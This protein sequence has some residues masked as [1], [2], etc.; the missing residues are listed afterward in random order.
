MGYQITIGNKT[1]D[2]K[3][4]FTIKE[5]FNETLDSGTV[6]F[7]TYG[8]ELKCEPFDKATIFHTDNIITPKILEVDSITDDIYC[9]GD[10]LDD[11]DHLYTMTLFSETKDLERATM[12][13]CAISQPLD[14][15]TDA[16]ITVRDAIENYCYC[17]LPK[18]KIASNNAS[19]FSYTDS[20]KI[21][22]TVKDKFNGVL[23]PEF[24][25]DNP[26]LREVLNDLF[27]VKDCIPVVK[28]NVI[29]L[30]DLTAKNN[31][32]DT[33]RL[34][35]MTS[36]FSSNDYVS[37]LTM[38]MK[39][40]VGKRIT[41]SAPYQCC[42]SVDESGEIN[43]NNMCI[44][45]QKPI[46]SVKSLKI[47]FI[48]RNGYHHCCDVAS[49]TIEYDDW[50]LKSN[51]NI[52]PSSGYY[53]LP[54][55][56]DANG[57]SAP[58]HRVNYIYYKRG[59]NTVENLSTKYNEGLLNEDYLT[60]LCAAY[61]SSC[62]VLRSMAEGLAGNF[63]A[64]IKTEPRTMFYEIEYETL[65][66]NAMHF[67]KNIPNNHPENRMF[68]NQPNAYVDIQ[69]QSIFEYAKVNRLS[70]QIKEVYSEYDNESEVPALGD[71]IDEYILFSKETTYYDNKMLFHGFLTKN[72]ILK[73]YYTGIMAKKRSWQIASQDD[74]LTK[75]EIAKFY[76]EASFNRKT[77]GIS[78]NSITFRNTN[79][80]GHGYGFIWDL[81]YVKPLGQNVDDVVGNDF[82]MDFIR[83]QTIQEISGFTGPKENHSIVMDS[84][85]EVL[86]NSLCWTFGFEDNYKSAD[87]VEK[88][89]TLYTQNFYPYADE[90]GQ[91][92][93]IDIDICYNIPPTYIRIVLPN[94]ANPSHPVVVDGDYPLPVPYEDGGNTTLSDA[95]T[96]L[97]L[98]RLKPMCYRNNLGVISGA[99]SYVFG[100]TIRIERP[101]DMRE[102]FKA[103]IQ[104]EY[105]S[106]TTD[107][108]VKS[109]FI[110]YVRAAHSL[111]QSYAD[112]DLRVYIS[113]TAIYEPNAKTALGD[114][115]SWDYCGYE[116]LDNRSIRIYNAYPNDNTIKSWAIATKDGELLL[117][118]N[119]NKSVYFNVLM[120]RDTNIYD[121]VENRNVV[122]SIVID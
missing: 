77:D 81:T 114:Q 65:Y 18:I 4:G 86:G 78:G 1:Y 17:Y 54:Q 28:N 10:Q 30:Y 45:T 94:P 75:H 71:Y 97:N 27:L 44:I 46:Y 6:Q 14:N 60:F 2:L 101:K 36:N 64:D 111:H 91:F 32:I 76:V 31:P 21:D 62:M 22:Q 48:D 117:A 3:D 33:S 89:D 113:R 11:S 43:T 102:I 119:G 84:S 122:G 82:V 34:S 108:I 24:Q 96:Y 37:E 50:R 79:K 85:I 67:G 42:K 5:E 12:P 105:C 103:T 121:S 107:I 53:S 115:Y 69:Q 72:Y 66:E 109:K 120:S 41:K 110:E 25:W 15:D 56:T 61:Y 49:R 47:H 8:E 63:F 38:Y 112:S 99:T 23:S 7:V 35:R 83:V 70:N 95:N 19:G 87:Y 16:Q 26:T 106:D 59:G 88:D 116:N 57:Y 20:L 40:G 13:S 98:F 104:A 29:K 118:V 92:N 9:F 51:I 39:N 80:T 73:N 93:Y 52:S 55:W 90:H 100:F 68:D 74:A 58:E